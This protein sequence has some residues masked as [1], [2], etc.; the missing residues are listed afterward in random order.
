MVGKR[1][2]RGFRRLGIVLSVPFFLAGFV[3]IGIY[4]FSSKPT[5]FAELPPGYVLDKPE[6]GDPWPG[7]PVVPPAGKK[8]A[9]GMFDDLVPAPKTEGP[10][11]G[12]AILVGPQPKLTP[13]DYD[14]FAPR[15]NSELLLWAGG[16]FAAA[17]ALFL[18]SI[19][20]G[21]T[22]AGFASDR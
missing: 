6:P 3:L 8:S 17:T 20:V 16:L 18:F 1:V 4:P 11:D 2:M 14:P 21:W 7:V 12:G 9:R 13:V 10:A 22:L 5:A 19:A 15:R